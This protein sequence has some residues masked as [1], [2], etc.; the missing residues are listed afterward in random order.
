MRR[1]KYFVSTRKRATGQFP[2]KKQYASMITV[3]ERSY[4]Q[5]DFFYYK[6]KSNIRSKDGEEWGGVFRSTY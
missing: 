3:L 6:E 1:N 5:K 4:V 2:P